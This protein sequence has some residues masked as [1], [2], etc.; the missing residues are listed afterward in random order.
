MPGIGEDLRYAARRLRRSPGFA[1]TA[2]ITLAIGIGV[3]A[4]VFTL[5]NAV[6]FSGFPSVDDNDRIAYVASDRSACCLSHADFE[7]WRER[8]T[9]FKGMAAV[10]GAL[11]S[12]SD[13][14]GFPESGDA[15]EITP[16]R[17]DSSARARCLAAISHAAMVSPARR[18]WRS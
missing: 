4:A 2:I 8:S 5:S 14:A 3:N 10:R 18:P 12:L 11:V 13:T 17:S 15:T 7:D 1:I 6:L 9:S 16:R